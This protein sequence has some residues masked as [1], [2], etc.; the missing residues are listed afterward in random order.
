MDGKKVR[1]QISIVDNGNGISKEGI[2]NLFKDFSK[3]AENEN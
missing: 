1:V 2:Q 3:L